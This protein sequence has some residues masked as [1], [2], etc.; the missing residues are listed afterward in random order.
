MYS[1]FVHILVFFRSVEFDLFFKEI[2]LKFRLPRSSVSPWL[3]SLGNPFP[4]LIVL[5]PWLLHLTLS[6]YFAL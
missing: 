6:V 4:A 5:D 2:S 3:H 1:N